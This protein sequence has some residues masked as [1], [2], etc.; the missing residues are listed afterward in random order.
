LIER[1]ERNSDGDIICYP[2]NEESGEFIKVL[3]D[4]DESDG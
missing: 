4:L 3:F 2:K 1:G